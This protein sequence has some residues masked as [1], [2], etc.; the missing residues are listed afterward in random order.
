MD[1]LNPITKS[2]TFVDPSPRIDAHV[3]VTLSG[4]P[5]FSK[6]RMIFRVLWL[7]LPPK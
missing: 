4:G 3:R 7:K 1:R 5:G 2:V 6:K